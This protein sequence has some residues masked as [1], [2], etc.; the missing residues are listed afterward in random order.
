MHA[1]HSHPQ[2][3]TEK[4]KSPKRKEHR[5]TTIFLKAGTTTA[6]KRLGKRIE[7]RLNSNGKNRTFQLGISTGHF[8]LGLTGLDVFS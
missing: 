8:Y 3:F 2:Q 7:T 6:T 4:K 1:V 5:P